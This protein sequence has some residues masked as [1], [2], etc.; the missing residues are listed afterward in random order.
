MSLNVQFTL[1]FCLH[2]SNWS[3]RV[4]C[5]ACVGHYPPCSGAAA[6][7]LCLGCQIG[8]LTEPSLRKIGIAKQSPKQCTAFTLFPFLY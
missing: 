3:V 1:D 6:K 5:A 4:H 8:G 7:Q 2:R